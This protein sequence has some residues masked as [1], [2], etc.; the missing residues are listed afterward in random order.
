MG[1]SSQSTERE[2]NIVVKD[3]RGRVFGP[4]EFSR[5]DLMAVNIQRGRDH[6]LPDYNTARRHFGL[7]P[8]TSL[9]PREFREKTGAEVEDGVLKK[10]QSLHQDDPSQVDIWVGGLLET[11]DSGPGDL[12]SR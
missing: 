3:L 12:F 7:E 11:H 8:L 5:R 2:D 10:L 6:G 1:L 9:D 4:L